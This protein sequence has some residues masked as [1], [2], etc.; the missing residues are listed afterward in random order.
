MTL[1]NVSAALGIV[2]TRIGSEAD[3]SAAWP[4]GGVDWISQRGRGTEL[5]LCN[6]YHSHSLL[7]SP[8]KSFC[9]RLAN[10]ARVFPHKIDSS[11]PITIFSVS[12]LHIIAAATEVKVFPRPILSAPSAPGR[13]V[14]QNHLLTINHK[15]QTW[16]ARNFVPGR[17]RIEYLWPGA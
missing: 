16:C 15:A 11:N 6:G 12:T 2:T 17:A 5:C 8:G 13:S 9:A 14:S 10:S 7:I 4:C 3:V 1:L